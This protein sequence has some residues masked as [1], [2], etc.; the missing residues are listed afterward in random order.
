LSQA[1]ARQMRD[2]GDGGSIVNISSISGYRVQPLSGHYS[3]AKAAVRMTTEV[4]AAEWAPYKIRVNCIAPGAIDTKLYGAIYDVLP[5]EQAV[6]LR[7]ESAQR[8]P[9]KRIGDPEE[10]ASGILYLVAPAS[11]Y[12]TGQTFAIDGGALL[13]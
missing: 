1:A 2:Q 10:I 7:E 11:S 3:I 8:I 4:M 9:L 13:V 12:M 5:K 6:Q